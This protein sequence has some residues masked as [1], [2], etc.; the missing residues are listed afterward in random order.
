MKTKF[1]C[2]LKSNFTGIWKKKGKWKSFMSSEKINILAKVGAHIGT[3]IEPVSPLGLPVPTLNTIVKNCEE[4]ERSYVQCKT[5]S[6]QGKS[7]KHSLLEE[8]EFALAAWFKQA[9]A[10]NTSTDGTHLK[11]KAFHITAHLGNSQIF[12]FE[13]LD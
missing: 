9:C 11:E 2:E 10:G 4:I 1:C 6:K 8:L 3:C 12:S 13:W 5:F 7:L